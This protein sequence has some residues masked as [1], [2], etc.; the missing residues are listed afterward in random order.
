MK[1]VLSILMALVMLFSFAACTGSGDGDEVTKK[2]YEYTTG[3]DETKYN[4]PGTLPIFKEKQTIGLLLPKQTWMDDYETNDLTAIL[5]ENLNAEFIFNEL[6]SKEYTTKINL[7]AAAGGEEYPDA[8]LAP[9]GGFSDSL[10]ITLSEADVIQPMTDYYYNTDIAW[11]LQDAKERLGWDFYPYMTMSDGE[12]YALP[13]IN[14]SMNLA[15]RNKMFVYKPWF[16]AAGI[17]ITEIHTTEDFKNAMLAVVKNDPNGNGKADEVGITGA[18]SSHGWQDWLI[19]PFIYAGGDD[20]MYVKDGK[21]GFAFQEEEW[22]EGLRYIKELYDLGL[23]NDLIFSQ[24]STSL[25]SMLN[26]QETIVTAFCGDAPDS[27]ASDDARRSQYEAVPPLNSSW[28]G[29]KPLSTQ[30]LTEPKSGLLISM[31]AKDPETVFRFG[32]YMC[33]YDISLQNCYGVA[34]KDYIPAKEGD[35]GAYEYLGYE[36]LFTRIYTYK[37]QTNNQ[38]IS[39]GPYVRDISIAAGLIIP[40]DLTYSTVGVAAEATM[41]YID[42]VPEEDIVKLIYTEEENEIVSEALTNFKTYVDE[43]AAKMIRG[44]LDIDGDWDEFQDTL[45]QMNIEEALVCIQAA[46]DRMEAIG[47]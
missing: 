20:Y 9:D 12:I 42:A 21:V 27:I 30:N 29:G 16:D 5:E 18:S 40:E 2:T 11:N 44:D 46:Y 10:V 13:S 45:K 36:P 37:Q 28:N 43:T 7:M 31:N 47:K 39:T 15:V 38:W 24:D 3:Y 26:Y 35:V 33:S 25:Q 14:E 41:R 23:I 8:I 1:R 6:P 32:D 19:N 17:D 4:A 34:G 22:K